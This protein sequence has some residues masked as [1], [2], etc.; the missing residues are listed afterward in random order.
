MKKLIRVVMT[1]YRNISSVIRLNNTVR[2]KFDVKGGAHQGSALSPLLF[3]IVLVALS[4][5]FRSTPPWEMLYTDDLVT[6]TESLVEL[7]TQYAAWKYC[8]ESKELSVNLAKTKVMIC[9]I[10]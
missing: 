3:P 6:I 7:D 2:E 4:R 9:D 10:N 1:M 5:G 8:L